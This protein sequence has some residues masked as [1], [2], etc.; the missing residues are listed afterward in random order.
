MGGCSWHP[1][2]PL[3]LAR[4]EARNQVTGTGFQAAKVEKRRGSFSR[5][6]AKVQSRAF[7]LHATEHFSCLKGL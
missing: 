3:T 1:T 4:S 2:S 5:A 7:K 6:T